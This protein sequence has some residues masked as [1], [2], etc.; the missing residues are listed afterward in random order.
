MHCRRLGSLPGLLP[1]DSS[2]ISPVGQPKVS[3][4]IAYYLLRDK[5][6]LGCLVGPSWGL[7]QVMGAELLPPA[8]PSAAAQEVGAAVPLGGQQLGILALPLVSRGP[9]A[10]D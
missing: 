6:A 1:P 8:Q 9:W 3:P 2:S 7:K 4:D 5:I 10:G